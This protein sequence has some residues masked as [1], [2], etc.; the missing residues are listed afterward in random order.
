MSPAVLTEPSSKRL[1][2]PAQT[3]QAESEAVLSRASHL[4]NQPLFCTFHEGTLLLQGRVR[5]YYHKQIAQTLV[6]DIAGVSRVV[7]Q[8][9]VADAL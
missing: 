5:C 6:A 9:E 1:P 8:I 4:L 2:L 7:N 3:I